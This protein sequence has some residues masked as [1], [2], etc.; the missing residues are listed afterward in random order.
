MKQCVIEVKKLPD[1]P[2][3]DGGSLGKVTETTI[4]RDIRTVLRAHGWYVVRHQQG[5]GSQKGIPDL[6]ACSPTGV[7]WWIEVK[8]PGGRLSAD[9]ERFRDEILSR[10][11]NWLLARSL[12]DIEPLLKG[13]AA[14]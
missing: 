14:S 8:K 10:H 6:S 11:G 13:G 12:D 4:L 7:H 3:L 9:Q 2:C 1:L 5:L